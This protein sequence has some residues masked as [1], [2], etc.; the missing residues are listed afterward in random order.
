MRHLHLDKWAEL[1]VHYSLEVESGNRMLIHADID[2]MPLVEACYEAALAVGAYVECLFVHDRL[3]EH[4]LIKGT[5][6]QLADTPQLKTYAATHFDRLLFIYAPSNCQALT[7]VA[8]ERHTAWAH[9]NLPFQRA[10][11]ERKAAGEVR[12]CR[13]H[14]PTSAAAQNAAMG[15][16]EF[17]AFVTR[18]GFLDHDDP[19]AS[20]RVQAAAQQRAIDLLA[21]KKELRFTNERGTD[22]VVNIEGMQW[23]NLCGT[24]NFP[25]GEIYT[26]PNF[27]APDGGVNGVVHYDFPSVYRGV[28]VD[29]ITLTFEKG[30][31]VEAEATRGEGFF[32]KMIEIDSGAR[33]VGEIAIG[34]NYSVTHGVKDILFDEKIGGTFHTAL[35]MGY[36]E[37]GNRN[38]SALHWDLVCDLRQGG[39]I[40]ADGDC[41][42]TNGQFLQSGWPQA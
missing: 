21:T 41:I 37:T 7:E 2:G 29:G 28:E 10:V 17:E 13:T 40:Y 30:A 33:Y 16:S 36:P 25:D 18:A 42:A 12:W 11:M 27:S 19:I 39:H 1:L 6:A 26:G 14:Y 35:G 4:M 23:V 31:V 8:P 32:K 34:T 38:V 9:A 3:I 15:S 24:I 20:W 22:L 5:N